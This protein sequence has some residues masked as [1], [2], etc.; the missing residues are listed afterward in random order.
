MCADCQA[1]YDNPADRRFHAQPIACPRCGPVL[2]LLDREGRETAAG[3][4]ALT[5]A[6]ASRCWP[7][8]SWP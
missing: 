7:A 2:Q 3:D 4:A 6:V 8:A 1:E 5:E